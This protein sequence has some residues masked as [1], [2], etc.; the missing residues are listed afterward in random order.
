M[1]NMHS[2]HHLVE[3]S[4]S[5]AV[6]PGKTQR[7]GPVSTNN[8]I[9]KHKNKRWKIKT[10]K[11]RKQL[12]KSGQ[13]YEGEGIPSLDIAKGVTSHHFTS[14]LF[15]SMSI[16][17]SLPLPC[18]FHG[19]S[20]RRRFWYTIQSKRRSEASFNK[21]CIFTYITEKRHTGCFLQRSPPPLKVLSTK[22]C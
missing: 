1:R 16:L 11:T 13:D 18:F 22:S 5:E 21:K 9:V 20:R 8:K 2:L 3:M 7:P 17:T 14:F 15:T 4:P 19:N 12:S 10:I 6:I